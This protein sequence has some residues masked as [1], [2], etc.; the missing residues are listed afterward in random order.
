M[1][2]ESGIMRPKVQQKKEIRRKLQAR[3]ENVISNDDPDDIISVLAALI[4]V[5]VND[6]RA[7]DSSQYPYL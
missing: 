6:S 5:V 4:G 2:T 3:I 1:E 7:R